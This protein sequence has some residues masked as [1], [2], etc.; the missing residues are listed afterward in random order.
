MNN[1]T[2]EEILGLKDIC[3][4]FLHRKNNLSYNI[5]INLVRKAGFQKIG[6]KGSHEVWYH[7]SYRIDVP[8]SDI[9][10]LQSVKGK[11]KPYQVQQV[12]KFIRLARQ[13]NEVSHDK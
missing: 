3:D 13:K 8:L 6:G 7:P 4:D 9:I 2:L 1:I 5:L 11:A 12:V 10:T